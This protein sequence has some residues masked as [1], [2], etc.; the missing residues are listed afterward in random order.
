MVE[1]V[2][3]VDVAYLFEFILIIS[4]GYDDGEGVCDC[5]PHALCLVLHKHLL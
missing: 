3:G 5:L 4:E 1:G 2:G